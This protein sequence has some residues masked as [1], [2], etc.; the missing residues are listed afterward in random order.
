MPEAKL[1]FSYLFP[2]L[3]AAA[4]LIFSLEILWPRQVAPTGVN[5]YLP[6]IILAYVLF[7]LVSTIRG[8]YR[9]IT[10]TADTLRFDRFF[11]PPLIL[12]LGEAT[13][14]HQHEYG[15]TVSGHL[16]FTDPA[17]KTI[18]LKRASYRRTEW[19]PFLVALNH[20]LAA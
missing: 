20:R 16:V 5:S 13:R 6:Y 9:Q 14:H 8:Q 19:T 12:P 18:R 15:T 11:G 7:R 1:T 4:A 17:G 3:Y 2:G 10:L